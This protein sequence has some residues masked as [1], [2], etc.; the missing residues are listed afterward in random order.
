MTPQPEARN[1][2]DISARSR[3]PVRFCLLTFVL[4][5]P[6]LLLGATT[7]LQLLPGIPVS[8]FAFVCP[9]IAAAILVYEESK[10]AGVRDL[11]KRALDYRRIRAKVWY[12]PL[13]LLMPAI[14]LLTY[15]M[16]RLTGTPIPVPQFSLPAA[17]ATF[18]AFCLAGL[19]EEL[20]WSGY[21]IDPLQ[22]RWGALRASV[23]VGVVWA[24]WHYVSLIQVHRS[25]TWIA[26]WSLY[27]VALRVLIVWLY[28]NTGHSVFAAT[29]F[30]ALSNVSSVTYSSCFDPRVTGL[31]VAFVA[32][33]VVIVW[34]PRTLVR[35]KNTQ[36][37]S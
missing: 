19:A 14:S 22:D 5:V 12:V 29:V 9:G 15:G 3:S 18:L 27:T 33:I 31:I 20:G 23:L 36:Q 25:T 28:N 8:A 13:T 16:M 4:S 30:H 6:F 21:V 34:G 35:T 1:A 7:S 26:W 37:S 10:S 11:L 17:L 32:T 2:P 24:V